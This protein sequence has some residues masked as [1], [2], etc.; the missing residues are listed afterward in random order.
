MLQSA[1]A[2]RL[3]T[4]IF[5]LVWLRS[6][7]YLGVN[8]KR[9]WVP[10]DEGILAQAAERIV[11]GEMPHRDFKGPYTGGLSYF[12]AVAFRLFGVDLLVLGYVLF[13]FFLAWVPAG[14]A[15][16]REF[17]EPRPAAGITL[18]GGLHGVFQITP[19]P[20]PHGSVCSS[21]LLALLLS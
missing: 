13:A 5:L 11:Q 12:H 20:Y 16:A 1:P 6:A 3:S 8:L 9:C 10:H 7:I 2:S 21:R 14:Y 18:L 17:S 15:A 19:P 4:L